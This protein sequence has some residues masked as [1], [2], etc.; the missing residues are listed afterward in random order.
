MWCEINLF[1]GHFA[2]ISPTELSPDYF[3][4]YNFAGVLKGDFGDKFKLLI[5]LPT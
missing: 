2:L 4:P 1:L 5:R 3:Y